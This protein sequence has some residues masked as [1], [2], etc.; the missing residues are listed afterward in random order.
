L[1][2]LRLRRGLTQQRVAERMGMTQPEV[3][4]L[5]RRREVTLSTVRAY[6]AAVG[7]RLELMARF[8][9]ETLPIE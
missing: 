9:D 7:G 5:E 2:N 8:D 4:K 6:V 3:S 1:R